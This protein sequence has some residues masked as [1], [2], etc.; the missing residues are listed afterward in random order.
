MKKP[1]AKPAA[2]T[3]TASKKEPV[4]PSSSKHDASAATG[5]SAPSGGG[6]GGGG[7]GAH[8]QAAVGANSGGKRSQMEQEFDRLR[9]L[10]RLEEG[11]DAIGPRGLAQLCTE[12]GIREGE[13]D[14]LIL[15]WKLGA[16]QSMCVTRHEWIYAMYLH[17]VE[18]MGQLRNLIPQWRQLCKEDDAAFSEMYGHTYD[19]IRSDDEKLLPLEKAVKSWTSLLPE[20]RFPFLSLW[21]Q[22]LTLEYK[23]PISRDVWRQLLEFSQKIKDPEAYDPNDK[24]PTAL[25]DF[26]EWMLE[27]QRSSKQPAAAAVGKH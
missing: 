26:V 5:K 23:R 2:P 24:W 25:D 20:S 3:A 8:E 19:F 7:A 15:A 18:H 1:G 21:A 11:V 16:T 4:P 13:A 14:M 17:K 9:T 10:D 27:K 22:W 12:L 6:G